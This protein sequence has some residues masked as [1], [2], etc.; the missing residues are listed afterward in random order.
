MARSRFPFDLV[1]MLGDNIYDSHTADDYAAKF[2]EPYKPL[3]DAGVTFQA[4]I[5]N[6]DD[7]AQIRYD[8]FNMGGQRYYSF[9]RAAISRSDRHCRRR[10]ALLR[11]RQPHARSRAARLA[12]ARH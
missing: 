4:A 10:R 6:H 8:K 9:R 1:L 11:P 5:G 3:L 7:P 2:E 12:A